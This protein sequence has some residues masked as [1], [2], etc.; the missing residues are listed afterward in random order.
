MDTQPHKP[1]GQ[2]PHEQP[3]LV[4]KEPSGAAIKRAYR[5]LDFSKVLIWDSL[6][7][8]DQFHA[9]V[10]RPPL[11]S[12]VVHLDPI[13][14]RAI[15]T[16]ANERNRP[17]SDASVETLVAAHEDGDFARTGDTIKFSTRG[18]L[19]DGQ[20]RLSAGIKANKGFET[21]MVFG[22]DEKI[23][24]IL[25]R[26]RTRTAGDVLAIANIKNPII[27]AGAVRWVQAL[28]D[29]RRGFGSNRGLSPRRVRELATG[30]MK[31]LARYANAAEQIRG[32]Y[33]IPPT[34]STALLFLIGQGTPH[35]VD[36]FV[37]DWL[38]GNRNYARNKNFDVLLSHIQSVRAKNN[39]HLNRTVLAAA[40]VYTFNYWHA[41]VTATP[42]NLAWSK[43]FQFPKL[44]FDKQAFL[45]E[46]TRRKASETSLP[47]LQERMLIALSKLQ[48]KDG[49]VERRVKDL[50]RAATIDDRHVNYVLGTLEDAGLVHCARKATEGKPGH[51]ATPAIWRLKDAGRARVNELATA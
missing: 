6:D 19:I 7:C 48:D 39:G 26:Q 34:M 44:A 17:L 29:Q 18:R 27:V 40:L 42:R 1:N 36:S 31:D 10:E 49:N 21:H 25:D 35:L 16:I 22:L 9:L 46:R 5:E 51:V 24:D 12:V 28:R 8:L 20:Y 2:A 14:G 43:Q 47:A 30:P 13:V 37:Q 11:H 33:K 3:P 45:D 50:A 23:F 32:A 15:L 38:G 41:G 4:L